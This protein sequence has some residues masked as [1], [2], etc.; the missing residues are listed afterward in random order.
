MVKFRDLGIRS[1]AIV[2]KGIEI[3][4]LFDQR[5]LIEKTKI[6]PT[7]FPG[8]N[9]S[10]LRMQM[11]VVLASFKDPKDIQEGSRNMKQIQKGS[12]SA[13]AV[14]VSPDLTFCSNPFRRP[15]R[16]FQTST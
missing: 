12:R 9:R 8:K 7:N 16:I 10:G 15:K 5:I 3:E 14:H 1:N 11:Q 4:D 2:G 13:N 6:E